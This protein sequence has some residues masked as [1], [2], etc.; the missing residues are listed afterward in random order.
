MSISEI[1]TIFGTIIGTLLTIIFGIYGIRS[2]NISKQ[3]RQE[4]ISKKDFSDSRK[5]IKKDRQAIYNHVL[6]R[7]NVGNKTITLKSDLHMLTAD[8]WIPSQPIPIQSIHLSMVEDIP[9]KINLSPK[10]LPTIEGKKYRTYADAIEENDRPRMFEDNKQYRLLQI[11]KK[12]LT[13]SRKPYSYFD[14][15]NYGEYLMYQVYQAHDRK[16]S[17]KTTDW[18]KYSIRIRQPSDHI[19]LCGINTLTLLHDGKDLRFLMHLRAASTGTAMGTFHVI[20]AGEFQPSC[21]APSA[22]DEDFDLWKSMMR[23]YSEEILGMEE[24]D[25]NSSVPF[26][27]EEEPFATLMKEV[28]ANTIK[29]YYLGIALDPITLQAE[30]LTAVVFKESVFNSV[31]PKIITTNTEGKIITDRNR[32]GR[33]FTEQEYKNYEAINTLPAGYGALALGWKHRK[34]FQNCFS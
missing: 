11:G 3:D 13:F 34:F 6:I 31:F 1:L 32:W 27:Y 18:Y 23:E 19:L 2:Y 4:K 8:D 16:K 20:P 14:K 25:G 10:P 22:F 28:A 5:S 30:I 17:L 33:P 12:S 15:V 24:W 9:R 21:V 7:H 26:S 29:P